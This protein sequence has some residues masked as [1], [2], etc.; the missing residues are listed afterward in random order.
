MTDINRLCANVGADIKPEVLTLAKAVQAMEEKLEQ[1]APIYKDAPLAQSVTVGTGET[2]VR[3]NPFVQEYRALIRDYTQALKTLQ[4]IVRREEGRKDIG[5]SHG[6]VGK[7]RWK[8]S[9]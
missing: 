8:N 7:S 1:Q 6:L 3:A 5:R 4:E 2:V 9:A